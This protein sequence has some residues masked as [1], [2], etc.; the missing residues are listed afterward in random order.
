MNLL[1]PAWWESIS[2]WDQIEPL[3]AKALTHGGV[4]YTP[5]DILKGILARDMKL[6]LAFEGDLLK[7]CAVTA[8]V[9]YP[10]LKAI[11]VLIIAGDG[12]DDWLMFSKDVEAWAK[13]DG[14]EAV[15]GPGRLGWKKKAKP[16]GYEPAVTIYRKMLT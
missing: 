9:R 13:S 1:Q 7:A 12:V 6:W 5:P 2:Y 16:Y 4:T 14:A 8:R 3:I 11:T 15:E 10:R